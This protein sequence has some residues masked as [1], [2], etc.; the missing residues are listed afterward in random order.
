M[1]L[2]EVT[3]RLS[4]RLPAVDDSGADALVPGGSLLHPA[5]V[6]V[7]IF[8]QGGEAVFLLT[9]RPETLSNHPGQISLPGGRVEE[10]DRSLWETALRETWEELGI[11]PSLVNPVGQLEPV[12]AVVSNHLILPFVG[13]LVSEPDLRTQADEVEEVFTATVSSL[14]DPATARQETWT[15]R[16]NRP[17]HVSYYWLGGHIVWGLTARILSGLA[18]HLDADLGPRPPGSVWPAG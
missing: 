6:L 9:R 14:L 12:Q 16:G 3:E 11:P 18:G 13:T 17:Y 4:Q 10:T 1:R 8:P 2:S 5:A 15:L 7:A